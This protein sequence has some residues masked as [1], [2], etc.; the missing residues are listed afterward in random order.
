MKLVHFAAGVLL[1]LALLLGSISCGKDT[2]PPT[3]VSNLAKTTPDNSNTPA[4]TWLAATDAGSGVAAY[5]VNMDNGNWIDVGQATS[6]TS[7]AALSDGNHTFDVKAV[8]KAGNEGAEVSLDF[9]CDTTPPTDSSANLARA[10]ACNGSA[11]T[12]TWIMA[13]DYQGSGVASYL[14]RTDGGNWTDIG[15][16]MIYTYDTCP[17]SGSHVLELAAKDKAG[18]IAVIDSITFV[19]HPLDRSKILA[20]GRENLAQGVD[21]T[22][23][24]ADVVVVPIDIGPEHGWYDVAIRLDVIEG[25]TENYIDFYATMQCG[26]IEHELIR[27]T[28]LAYFPTLESPF[29]YYLYL[30]N[31]FCSTHAKVVHLSVTWQKSSPT[32]EVGAANEELSIAE[33]AAEV[34][35]AYAGAR[36]ID[37]AVA[38]WDGSSGHVTCT[39]GGK[40]Y[41]AASYTCGMGTFKATYDVALNGDITAGHNVSWSGIRWDSSSSIQYWVSS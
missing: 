8:D 34:C 23:P 37:A 1:S 36:Q 39:V 25:G 38:A 17:A 30:D 19:T 29:T 12:F 7:T 40:V 15:N 2:T 32:T 6:Y 10:C 9:I 5:L 31:A 24:P 21:V 22:V 41:D 27:T 11:P 3:T 16:V 18:N 20:Y 13:D 26:Y 35:R 4:F 28:G 33:A 14:V